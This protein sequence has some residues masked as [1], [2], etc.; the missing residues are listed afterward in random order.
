MV[1]FTYI[2]K[3]GHRKFPCCAVNRRHA[4]ETAIPDTQESMSVLRCTDA[5]VH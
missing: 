1:Y 2:L 3:D 4:A 5:G